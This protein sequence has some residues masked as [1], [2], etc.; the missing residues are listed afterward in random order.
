MKKS[1]LKIFILFLFINHTVLANETKERAGIIFAAS[2]LKF[3]L[4][5]LVYKFYKKYPWT[6][7]HIQYGA[8]GTLTSYILDDNSNYDIFFSADTFYPNK[9]YR[10]KKSATKP[11]KYA[12][13][14]LILV[15]P[16]NAH[17]K[18]EKLNVLKSP[19]IQHIDIA[20][21]ASAPYGKA[22]LEV[23]KKTP[24]F[25]DLKKK[26]YYSLDGATVISNVIWNKSAGFLP[27]S[28]LHR[29]PNNKNTY[30][31]I[32]I[33]HNL[34]NPIIQSYVVSSKGL[35]N[36]NAMKFLEFFKSKIG[37]QIFEDYGYKYLITK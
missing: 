12:Q 34:Y 18:K 21:K 15:T 2:N 30:S 37:Q 35:K 28:A 1:L 33:D 6:S 31:W 4:P 16:P 13:G 9:V 36:T 24:Y 14:F 7:V 23:L 32:E 3:V 22:A 27:K 10:A 29:L 19:S 20:N 11:K 26:I 5:Q 8:S 25:K 17:L